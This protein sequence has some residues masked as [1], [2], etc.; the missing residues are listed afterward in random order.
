MDRTPVTSSNIVSIW[1]DEENRVLEIEF[2]NSGVYQYTWI[3]VGICNSLMNA[4]SHG[5]YFNENIK[6]SYS[7]KKIS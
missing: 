1:Y 4:S 2:N 6:N 3:P 7:Y 5:Q